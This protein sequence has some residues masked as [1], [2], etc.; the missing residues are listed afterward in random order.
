MKQYLTG[1][2]AVLLVASLI[3]NGL[4]YSRY[5]TSRPVVSF[6]GGS[7]TKKEFQDAL[8][9]QS[10]KPVLTKI[11]YSEIVEQAAKRAGVLAT[12]SDINTRLTELQRR[13]PQ[14]LPDEKSEP[15][16]FQVFKRDLGTDIS[17]ENLRLKGV[18]VDES[19][20]QEFYQKNK[21]QFTLPM[22]VGT[23]MVVTDN[24]QDA[25]TAE[26]DL[27]QGLG[28]DV[29]ARQPGLHVVGVNGFKV[30]MDAL[31]LQYKNAISATVFRMKPGEIKSIQLGKNFITFK[32]NKSEATA[33]PPLSK[34]H[35][36]VERQ[37]RLAKAIGPQEMI[38]RLYKEAKPKFNIERYK[39]YFREAEMANAGK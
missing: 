32:V 39:A 35:A 4:L 22:Q 18:T 15:E 17:L 28:E 21:K 2:L 8:E 1:I 7:V 3:A 25:S 11:V 20:I 6:D 13:S 33:V 34:I 16:K 14:L 38:L 19:E 26:A 29:I 24:S 5:S 36:E 23:T 9:F 10:G 37:A 31:P 30:N 12:E 27:K